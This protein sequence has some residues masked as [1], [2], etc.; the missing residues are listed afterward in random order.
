MARL[1]SSTGLSYSL[2][3]ESTQPAVVF[4]NGLGGMQESWFF[5]SRAL[6]PSHRVLAYDHRG[7]GRSAYREGPPCMTTYVDD[8]IDLMDELE[9]EQAD[10]VGIS[11]GGRLLQE[12]GLTHPQ[13][14]RSLTL[15]A[16]SGAPADPQSGQV[17]KEMASMPP[18]VFL[19][20]VVPMLFGAAYI[21][22]NTRRLQTYAK[23]RMRHRVDP[24]GL[25]MQWEAICTFD[26]RDRLDELAMPVLVLHGKE[27]KMTPYLAAERL[28]DAIVQA[29]LVGFEGL[30]HSPHVEDWMAFNK[31]FLAFL[32]SH[33]EL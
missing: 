21:E 1:L 30:G 31:E 4:V 16:T 22:N 33:S 27:D 13:R 3:G 14:V 24:R 18:E 6:V 23:S 7:N 15:C 29:K 20:K 5:Q 19:E 32:A 9:I 26:V 2:A 12:L 8:L 28:S 11:F 10:F 25:A 17:L